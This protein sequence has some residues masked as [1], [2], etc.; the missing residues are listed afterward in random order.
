MTEVGYKTS[1]RVIKQM[2]EADGLTSFIVVRIRHFEL[3]ESALLYEMKFLRKINAAQNIN[4]LNRSN[5]GGPNGYMHSDETKKKL[6]SLNKGNV[7]WNNGIINKFC[8]ESPGSGWILGKY[9]SEKEFK[10]RS[11]SLSGSIYWNNGEMSIR[12]KTCPGIGWLLG[13]L[14]R[15]SN[16][17]KKKISEANKGR[18]YWNDGKVSIASKKCPGKD[19]TLGALKKKSIPY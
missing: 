17:T 11:R 3:R 7:Y 13:S 1:S 12:S 16:D 9:M 6:Q 5:G 2:I 4:F 19:W 18:S 14:R 8:K 15:V 10:A